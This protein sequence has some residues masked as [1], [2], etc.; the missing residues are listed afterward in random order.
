MH[1]V[2]F[3][4]RSIV[5]ATSRFGTPSAVSKLAEVV[6]PE[7]SRTAVCDSRIVAQETNVSWGLAPERCRPIGS[8]DAIEATSWLGPSRGELDPPEFRPVRGTA[9][10]G[11]RAGDLTRCETPSG[12]IR[13]EL[14][15]VTF[16]P[17]EA[18]H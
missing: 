3:S 6:S 11:R 7:A 14:E 18:G 9:I 1:C 8:S 15:D 5:P 2:D 17:E 12:C 16:Q 10:L 13:I 4:H